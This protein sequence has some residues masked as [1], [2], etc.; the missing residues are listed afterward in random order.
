MPSDPVMYYTYFTP[1]ITWHHNYG[2]IET[3]WE[4]DINNIEN[5]RFYVKLQ[6]LYDFGFDL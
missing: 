4:G 6:L 1:V 5:N 2:I 3:G